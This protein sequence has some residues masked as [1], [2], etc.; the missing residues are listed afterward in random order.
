MSIAYAQGF[1]NAVTPSDLVSMGLIANT[2][3]AANNR[4]GQT[5]NAIS[6][7]RANTGRS[8]VYPNGLSIAAYPGAASSGD[9]GYIQMP[10]TINQL[11]TAGGFVMGWGGKFN[12]WSGQ[13]VTTA[14]AQ[15]IIGPGQYTARAVGTALFS[16]RVKPITATNNVFMQKWNP[17]TYTWDNIPGLAA[18]GAG[19][20]AFARVYPLGSGE[21]GLLNFSATGSYSAGIV[22][23]SINNTTFSSWT[24]ASGAN[25]SMAG[26]SSGRATDY[27]IFGNATATTTPT[28]YVSATI[29]GA[30]TSVTLPA[31]ASNSILN[32]LIIP[33]GPATGVCVLAS[34]GTGYWY[35]PGSTNALNVS[36]S[37]QV[38][39]APAAIYDMFWSAADSYYIVQTAGGTYSL[40]SMGGTFT[41]LQTTQ[42]V[43]QVVAFNGLRFGINTNGSGSAGNG[44]AILVSNDNGK[45]W[46]VA[47]NALSATS[48][49]FMF[50]NLMTD[51]TYL[52]ATLT[53]NGMVRSADG[54]TWE[55]V[56]GAE[57][58]ENT[59]S[60]M[61]SPVGLLCSVAPNPT[62]FQI[63]P[64]NLFGITWSASSNGSVI[65]SGQIK[66]P[67]INSATIVSFN[68][69]C[70]VSDQGA[71]HFYELEFTP[72]ATG[73][74]FTARFWIDGTLVY[75]FGTT[76]YLLAP[77]ATDTTTY[78][79]FNIGR[80]GSMTGF[81][82]FLLIVKDG[83]GTS[84]PIGGASIL[85]RRL[86]GDVGTPGWTRNPA[87][88]GT[89][90]AAINAGGISTSNALNGAGAVV[91][92][93]V[94]T[95]TDG[96]RDEY[97]S[98]DAV[99]AQGRVLGVMTE[100]FYT[101]VSGTQATINQGVRSGGTDA[102]TTQT[103]TTTGATY[104]QTI[105]ETAPGGGAWST[106]GA[107]GCDFVQVKVS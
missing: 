66:G 65:R 24:V 27:Y 55:F 41:A 74:T 103:I 87:N 102:L 10:K 90:A 4:T 5:V 29:G 68:T 8:Y 94:S 1:E 7:G 88:L 100:A 75:D 19:T 82:D 96:A 40:P 44:Q 92:R 53:G 73:N 34:G 21:V 28:I 17:V 46:S 25:L 37:W 38:S 36:T 62:T 105:N 15:E 11:W 39:T 85:P 23:Y 20:A 84:G 30:V 50:S 2:G 35:A 81:D 98:T 3:N 42:V 26:K 54:F 51:G 95:D 93:R 99:A 64:T 80:S 86:N 9:P 89:N 33:G 77:N 69:T 6:T 13:A 78:P 83:V 71:W 61:F 22:Q 49:G 91:P 58:T 63:A 107:D 57:N 45:S 32:T 12:R 43:T 14:G 31:A 60:N 56:W 67:L 106:S 104:K 48:N 101:K 79:F 52:Y 72:T 76:G 59:T 97:S 16:S 47:W 70:P 18:G